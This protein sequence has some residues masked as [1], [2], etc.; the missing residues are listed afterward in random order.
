MNFS[1]LSQNEKLALYGAIVV[2]LAGLIS[3]WGGL[4]WLAVIAAAGMAVV[5]FLPQVAPTTSLP[6]SKGTLMATLGVVALG[7]GI[8]EVLR[9]V[10]YIIGFD[11][12]DIWVFLVALVGAAV[13]AWAGWQELQ[14]E[15]GKWVFGS[16]PS[17]GNDAGSAT[18]PAA[19]AGAAA[20]SPEPSVA[21]PRMAD[22]S[23][24][25]QSPEDETR[26]PV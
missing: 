1:K 18:A 26:P 5:I 13:M 14:R 11:E 16:S 4:F 21:D 9:W 8:I 17:S 6:G 10:G 19:N 24:P 15:G 7:A 23:Q 3:N 20:G 2:F 22:A 25:T 12:F